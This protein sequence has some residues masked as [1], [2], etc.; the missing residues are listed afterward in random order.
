MEWRSTCHN[1]F[2]GFNSSGR[3]GR[4]TSSGHFKLLDDF[5]QVLS[6]LLY[7]KFP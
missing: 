5:A 3:A 4:A 1:S 2:S 6:Q 7:K